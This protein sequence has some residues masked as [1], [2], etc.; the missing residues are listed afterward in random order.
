MIALAAYCTREDVKGAL[1]AAETWRANDRIDRAIET[2]A[3]QV[4]GFLRR[5]FT[6]TLATRYFNWPNRASPTPWRLWFD[7]DEVISLTALTAGGITI[8]AADYFLEPANLGPPYT[9]I[10][11]DLSSNSAFTA[12]AT[13]QH[14]IAATGLFGYSDDSEPVGELAGPLAALPTATASITWSTPR[15]GVGHLLR[16]DDERMIVTDR[17][18]VDSGQTLQVPLTASNA[19]VAVA[20]AAGS[21]F[22]VEETL[23]L[24]S[25]RMRVIDIA[26]NTLTVKR[27]YDGT[28]LAAHTGTPI[29]TLTGVTLARG[30]AGTTI[31]SHLAA[32]P[33]TRHIVPPVVRDLA[34]A[35][36]L[37]QLAQESSGYTRTA[38]TES[39][40]RTPTGKGSI[41]L[42]GRGIGELEQ[43]ALD[44]CGRQLLT[45]AV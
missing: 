20:V 9:Y 21:A 26:G 17:Q 31:A 43:A 16:I 38:G 22:A 37:N 41:L 33:I 36:S 27:A 19:D 8:P 2:A 24:D 18:M 10:E 1:D 45:R 30:Q 25:E 4:D 39:Q 15:I 32:A 14:A 13:R 40:A 23:L 12:G 29:W 3:T 44:V 42:T 5:R 11:I 28:V 7:Y 35:Y 34:L 6:P